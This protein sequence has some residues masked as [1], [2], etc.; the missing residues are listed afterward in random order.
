[1][2]QPLA[3]LPSAVRDTRSSATGGRSV[4]RHTRSR[5]SR[6]P[7][8]TTR[9]AW[10]SQPSQRAWHHGLREREQMSHRIGP[11]GEQVSQVGLALGLQ[12]GVF[13]LL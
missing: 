5:R 7:G 3:H 10:R 4:E 6:S 13:H 1:M 8:G 9:P 2:N 12:C 11:V